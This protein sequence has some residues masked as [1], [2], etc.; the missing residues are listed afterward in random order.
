MNSLL[1][2]LFMALVARPVAWI[3]LGIN[4][5]GWSNLPRKGP[6]ILVANHNSHLDTLIILSLFG[7]LTVRKVRPL[8]AA[9]YFMQTALRRFIWLRL[10]GSIPVNRDPR[11]RGPDGQRISPLGTCIAALNE[12]A[13]VL[14]F[15]EGSR[16][17]PEEM[18]NFKPGVAHL[19]RDFPDVPVV[20]IYLRGAGKALPRGEALLVPFVCDVA[21]GPSL[22]WT[23]DNASFMAAVRG[24]MDELEA[25]MP[26]P[27]WDDEPTLSS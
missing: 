13:I 17:E 21:V 5:R 6:A 24:A 10:V 14:V 1:R 18:V 2:M 27:A 22:R 19:A 16:G 15:P 26:T 8:A 3:V 4:L 7:P 11:T 25:S 12:G 9:D 23:G 20:P